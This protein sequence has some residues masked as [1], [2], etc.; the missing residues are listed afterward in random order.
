M[1]DGAKK[2]VASC[3][4]IVWLCLAGYCFAE[5]F[6]FFQGNPEKEDQ[7]IEKVLSTPAD[8]F[9][10]ADDLTRL[11]NPFGPSVVGLIFPQA[12]P[13]AASA[14]AFLMLF[15]LDRYKPSGRQRLNLL[16]IFRI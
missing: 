13:L 8:N 4:V 2:S 15:P 3:L 10:P 14:A 11:P 1:N 12:L 6:G 5:K 16:S 7:S 9:G